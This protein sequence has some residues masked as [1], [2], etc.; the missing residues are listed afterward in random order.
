[1]S[2]P[3]AKHQKGFN[4]TNAERSRPPSRTDLPGQSGQVLNTELTPWTDK[5]LKQFWASAR[6]AGMDREDV[7]CTLSARYNKSKLHDLT[8]ME[9]IRLIADMAKKQPY[10]QN[11]LDGYFTGTPMEASWRHIRYLQRRLRWSDNDLANYIKWHGRKTGT[12]IEHLKWL[13][14]QKSRGI[15]TGMKK[16]L[17][18]Q[19]DYD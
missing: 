10:R 5:E 9:F 7:Y 6:A 13:T 14:V 3:K 4:M 16:I 19:K 18:G 11:A 8:R 17:R 1:M 12:N 2:E 15:I